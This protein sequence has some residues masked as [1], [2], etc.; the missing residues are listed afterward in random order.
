M[1]ECEEIESDKSSVT[2][3]NWSIHFSHKSKQS[4]MK[5]QSQYEETSN[6]KAL[7]GNFEDLNPVHLSNQ[8]S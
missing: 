8:L 1:V 2:M 6:P 7:K 5:M 3:C 4:Q